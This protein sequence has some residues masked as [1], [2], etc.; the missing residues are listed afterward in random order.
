MFACLLQ[1][2]L[3]VSVPKLGI[4][5]EER[6]RELPDFPFIYSVLASSGT[7]LCL[8]ALRH[9]DAWLLLRHKL[10]P[11]AKRVQLTVCSYGRKLNL[12]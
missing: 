7:Y 6:E 5:D 3:Y 4:S 1:L 9:Y 8:P 10:L 12:S 2:L 11:H